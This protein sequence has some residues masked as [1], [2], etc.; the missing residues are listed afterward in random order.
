MD[1]VFA[2]EVGGDASGFVDDGRDGGDVPE[3]DLGFDHGVDSSG[4]EEDE[5]VAVGESA[6]VF[7]GIVDLEVEVAEL[8]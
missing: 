2:V 1:G 3:G 5:A 8:R 7:G 6:C 4:G